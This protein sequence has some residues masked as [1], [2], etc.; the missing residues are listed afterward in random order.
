[1]HL[2]SWPTIGSFQEIRAKAN[3]DLSHS[4][5]LCKS[6]EENKDTDEV[7]TAIFDFPPQFNELPTGVKGQKPRRQLADCKLWKTHQGIQKVW[8]TRLLRDLRGFS[9]ELALT[10]GEQQ[11]HAAL[12]P[13]IP[14]Q[15]PARVQ[16]LQQQ[17]MHFMHQDAGV[18]IDR[19]PM[20]SI[21]PQEVG[22][23]NLNPDA[24]GLPPQNIKR[25]P[26]KFELAGPRREVI[27]PEIGPN[28]EEVDPEI[29]Q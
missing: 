23:A 11:Q 19:S 16:P 5:S 18:P 10:D 14:D 22:L 2:I 4:H 15:T 8:G 9:K 27:T 6:D 1:M 3:T 12:D 29:E 21:N 13:V 26:L 28:L 24:G 25:S 17:A 20:I 7:A